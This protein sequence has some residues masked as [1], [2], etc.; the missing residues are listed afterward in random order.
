MTIHK[1][2]YRQKGI[3]TKHALLEIMKWSADRIENSPSSEMKY[4]EMVFRIADDALDNPSDKDK[5]SLKEQYLRVKD[6]LEER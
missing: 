4:W 6:E 3:I 2:S 5:Q 1:L